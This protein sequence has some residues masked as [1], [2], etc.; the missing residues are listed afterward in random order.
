MQGGVFM[1]HRYQPKRAKKITHGTATPQQQWA[2]NLIQAFVWGAGTALL[3]LAGGAALFASF[4]VPIL[5]V[6]PAACLIAGAG[7]AVS[8]MV[9]A[10]KTG[11]FRLLCGL[12]CGAF[13]CLCLIVASAVTGELIWSQTSIALLGVLLC[14]GTLGGTIAALRPSQRNR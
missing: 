1:E 2:T 12:G 14:S 10:A 7:A 13:Y 3:L 5:L 6:R 11:R 8:G 4:P 9:L